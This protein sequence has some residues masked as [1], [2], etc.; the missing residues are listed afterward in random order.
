MSKEFLKKNNHEKEMGI[1]SQIT[2]RQTELDTNESN[3]YGKFPQNESQI[4]KNISKFNDFQTSHEN[5]TLLIPRKKEV[6]FIEEENNFEHLGLENKQRSEVSEENYTQFNVS[7][8]FLKKN[9][10]EKEMGIQSQITQRQTELDTNESNFYEK[11]P[12]NEA[13]IHKN[14]S[15]F[16]D[17][18]TS[19]EN[20]TLLIPR[21]KE[22]H[23]IE[24][25]NNFEHLVL[26]NKQRSEV[27]EENYTQFNVS[28]EFLKKNNHEEEM[29]IQSQITQRQTELD[30]NESNFYEKF[31]QNEAEIHKNIS[32]FNDFQKT[33]ENVTLV[34]PRKVDVH[35]TEEEKSPEQLQH[36]NTPSFEISKENNTQLSANIINSDKLHMKK[37]EEK[38]MCIHSK[39]TQTQ[40]KM[41]I[42]ESVVEY[43]L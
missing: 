36:E 12:Q 23:F 38:E 37:D 19:H 31:P 15:K 20:V 34:V 3:S 6:H 32:K 14:I 1:Q 2:Q 11:F 26:E 10:H 13:E 24:E 40:Q 22:V 5:V 42:D 41:D 16:N 30:T 4:D 21:K 29:G 25:E 7:K 39:I 27:S 43:K 18:Q 28:E 8:E 35:C 9:N 17:F 33:H